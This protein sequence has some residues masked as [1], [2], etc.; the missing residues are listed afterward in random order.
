M[1]TLHTLDLNFLGTP[2]VIASYLLI[3]PNSAALIESG[4]GS[5][6][7]HL[8]EALKLHGLQPSDV[9]DVLVTHI[10]LDHAG[11][12]GWWARQGATVYVH[13]VGA[14]HLI[15]PSK[16]LSSAQ[17]IYGD[18]MDTLWGEFLPSP[19]ERVRVV[20]DNEVL[21]IA[22]TEIQAINTPGHANHHYCYRIGDKLV[23]GDSCGVRL[24]GH[25]WI[26]IPTPPP[27]FDL[28]AWLATLN[29]I[30]AL[31]PKTLYLTHFGEVTE[32]ADHLRQYAALIPQAAEFVRDC[33]TNGL[34][35][36]AIIERYT[37]WLFTN[38]GPDMD[39]A[40]RDQYSKANGIA[41]G[42]D[43]LMR[44]WKKRLGS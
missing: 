44:Y 28:E 40:T 36:D 27:E 42:V 3:G 37:Q 10:H 41:M 39:A 21:T 20:N 9:R 4:P 12:A 23:T 6:L 18:R 5:T 31:E 11:A 33:M 7:N 22:G 38:A 13:P 19:A 25:N 30:T 34:N 24:P 32:A 14:P 16:L 35:R 8:L 1:T 15:D 2:H 17:R 26:G 29:R 43:G